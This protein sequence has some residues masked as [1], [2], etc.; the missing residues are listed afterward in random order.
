MPRDGSGV[1][2]TPPGTHGTPNTTILSANY[3]SNVDDVAADLNTPRP[4]VAGGTGA[5]TAAG[6][7]TALGAAPLASPV[8][9]GDPQAPTPTAGDNDTS[10]ATTAF[11]ATAVAAKVAKGGDTMTGHLF[12]T[13]NQ[14]VT[15]Q[16]GPDDNRAIIGLLMS[17]GDGV[18]NFG[19]ISYSANTGNTYSMSMVNVISSGSWTI[20]NDGSLSTPSGTAYK[21]GGGAWAAPSDARIKTVEGDYQAGLAQVLRLMPVIYRYKGNDAPSGDRSITALALDKSL[22]GLV[23]QEVES[24]FP[25]MVQQKTGWIDGVQVNDF[26]V[27]DTSE[28]IFALVN[29]IKEL[30]AR[31]EALEAA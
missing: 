19:Y 6:A 17:S 22:V 28:L 31:I 4:I 3:N 15:A 7:L 2:S 8:F 16:M 26:R 12:I 23:A 14:G 24:V 1:Y 20:Q 25:D 11:V 9:T 21:A 27:L 18:T 13:N 29:A 30:T 5:T 10:I